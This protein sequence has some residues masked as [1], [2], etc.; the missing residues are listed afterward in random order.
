MF[1]NR[2]S[3]VI[4]EEFRTKKKNNLKRLHLRAIMIS[5]KSSIS[6][7]KIFF[8]VACKRAQAHVDRVCLNSRKFAS[9]FRIKIKPVD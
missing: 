8:M 9:N 1:R 6:H 2:N 4:Q 5:R 3:R 7:E